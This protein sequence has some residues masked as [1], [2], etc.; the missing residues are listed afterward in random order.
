[1]AVNP[2][3]NI[4]PIAF[5][6]FSFSFSFLF[7]DAYFI[8]LVK[9]LMILPISTTGCILFGGSPKMMSIKVAINKIDMISVMISSGMA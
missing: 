9:K 8:L 7:L 4:D 5:S 3:A 6:K 2:N 1:M